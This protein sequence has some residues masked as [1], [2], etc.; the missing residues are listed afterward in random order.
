M[1]LLPNCTDSRGY[2]PLNT[3]WGGTS[4]LSGILPG[5]GLRGLQERTWARLMYGSQAHNPGGGLHY[6]ER[7]APLSYFRPNFA[8]ARGNYPGQQ[9][10]GAPNLGQLAVD[11]SLLAGGVG[12]LA[13]G[14]FLLGRKKRGKRR[15]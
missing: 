2:F 3:K 4:T 11:P 14:M 12:A 15:K 5:G 9:S 13:L 8:M 1:Y 10:V 7:P 6:F